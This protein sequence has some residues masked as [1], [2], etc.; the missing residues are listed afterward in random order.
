MEEQ[1][2]SGERLTSRLTPEDRRFLDRA[3]ELGRRGWGQVHPNPMVGCV[4][5]RD[6]VVV[7]EGWHRAYGGPHAEVEAL[8]EAGEKARGA[9]AYV[10]LEPCDHYG[11][12]P[13]C[14]RALLEAGVGRV[15]YGGSDPGAVSRGGAQTL[16]EGGVDVVGPVFAGRR[17]RVEN[18]A[19]YRNAEGEETFLALKLAQTLDGAIAEARGHRTTITG[20]EAHRETHRLRSGFDAVMVGSGTA[21]VDDPLLTVR[22]APSP[23]KPPVRIILDSRARLSPGARLFQD[24]PDTPVLLFVGRDAEPSRLRELEEA[25]AM[26]RPVEADAGGLDLGQVLRTCWKE[27]VRSVFCEGGG[28]LASRLLAEG[29]AHRLYLF[30]APFVLGG[31][32]VPAFPGLRGRKA[33]EGWE[34]T[35]APRI[36]GRDVLLTFDRNAEGKG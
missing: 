22:E 34:P 9:T 31:E 19:F 7:G 13:P 29:R 6:G 30:M 12:T 18:P 28:T 26:I 16:R 23:R 1:L 27:E 8:E 11:H 17:A 36:V 24:T 14:S 5:V 15:V 25:G 32:A 4:L 20:P 35:L 3:V 2:P 10:S 21:L 33:W